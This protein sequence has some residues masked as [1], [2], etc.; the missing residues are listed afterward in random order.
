M[1]FPPSENEISTFRTTLLQWYQNTKRDL[2]WR[3]TRDPYAIWVSEVMLQQTRVDTVIPYYEAFMEKYPDMASL[4]RSEPEALLKSWEGL[5]YYKRLQNLKKT[6]LFLTETNDARLPSDFQSLRELPGI[7][8]YIAAAVSSIAFHGKEAV[9]DGNVKR[10]LA[11]LFTD[12]APVNI[13]SSHRHFLRHASLL[14]D[15]EQ[16]GEANQALMELGAMVCTPA[17]PSC[18][19]CPVSFSCEALHT[20]NTRNYPVRQPKKIIPFYPVACAVIVN[21]RFDILITK[22]PETGMLPGFWE[23]P[24]GR[25]EGKESGMDACIREVFEETGLKI[26][27]P[28]KI[29]TIRHA[30]TH[31]RIEM[32]LFIC[33]ITEKERQNLKPIEHRWIPHGELDTLAFPAANRKCMPALSAWFQAHNASP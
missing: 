24:G 14:L 25:C 4:A 27:K 8:D 9:V 18:D 7:G 6:A 32:S 26:E 12:P 21:E 15:P 33:R 22:R 2:P 30:Y 16:P 28:E 10:V 5:G 23:F 11:R 17:R 3:R 29:C 19:G 20:D 31:F 13:S 1:H